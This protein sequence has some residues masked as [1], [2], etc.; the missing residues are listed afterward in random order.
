MV[1]PPGSTFGNK[2]S[3]FVLQLDEASRTCPSGKY[4]VHFTTRA[5]VD[6][7]SDLR[8]VVERLFSIQK[9][10]ATKPTALWYSYFNLPI[11]NRATS[12]VAVPKNVHVCSDPDPSCSYEEIAKEAREIF[13]TIFP[14]TPFFPPPPAEPVV[15]DTTDVSEET[16]PEVESAPAKSEAV[17]EVEPTKTKVEEDDAALEEKIAA[18]EEE[19]PAE[20]PTE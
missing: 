3:V 9:L 14:D 11:F 13:E 18:F 17:L 16:L 15:D 20:K 1:V 10:D 19:S 4:L 5:S 2:S 7:Q 8:N 6:A 12:K